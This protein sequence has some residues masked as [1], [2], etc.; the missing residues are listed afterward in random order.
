MYLV[1]YHWVLNVNLY[2]YIRFFRRTTSTHF[3][4]KNVQLVNLARRYNGIRHNK[5]DVLFYQ[6]RVGVFQTSHSFPILVNSD[7]FNKNANISP[8]H[9]IVDLN[10][11]PFAKSASISFNIF[12]RLAP[13]CTVG[14]A[15][16]TISK[17]L[18]CQF[19]MF[20]CY[21]LKALLYLLLG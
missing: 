2:S 12:F 1:Q 18:S 16:L 13:S 4:K 17:G 3:G 10:V 19:V 8:L 21:I 11:Y 15:L 9:S 5:N 6:N 20:I 7:S 14:S